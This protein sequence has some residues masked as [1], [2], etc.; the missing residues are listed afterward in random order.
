[1]NKAKTYKYMSENGMLLK[2]NIKMYSP[3]FYNILKNSEKYQ[4]SDGNPTG[5]TLVGFTVTADSD[6]Q[7]YL[8]DKAIETGS[9]SDDT[10]TDEAYAACQTQVNDWVNSRKNIG[11]IFDPSSK[12]IT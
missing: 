3:K 9:K 11:K 1:M 5:K 2:E 7:T 6:N 8:I 4:D 10:I 12:K